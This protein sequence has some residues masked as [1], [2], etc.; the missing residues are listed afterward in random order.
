MASRHFYIGKQ[1]GDKKDA[2]ENVNIFC[3]TQ[4]ASDKKAIPKVLM[5]I[6]STNKP[7]ILK[8]N[9]N[10]K[11]NLVLPKSKNITDA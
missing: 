2:E 7:A 6:A 10:S 3:T 5:S 11:D 8:F 1:Y 9:I 4:S